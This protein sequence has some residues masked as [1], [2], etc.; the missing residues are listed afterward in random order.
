M[1][2]ASRKVWRGPL[3]PRRPPSSCVFAT[4]QRAE[5][6]TLGPAGARSRRPNEECDSTVVNGKLYLFGGNPVA[7]AGKQGA[8]P[9]TVFEYD[10]AA[11]RWTKKKNMPQPAHHNGVVGYNGKIYVFGGG[12]QRQPGGPTQFPIDNAWEYDPAA[13]TWK[14]LA[15]MPIRRLAAAAVES[16]GKIYVM[17]GVAAVSRSRKPVARRRGAASRARPQ[18]RVRP[19]DQHVADA[20]DDADAAQPHVR[21]AR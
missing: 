4:A 21:R 9:G 19:G 12:V 14:A 16:G 3:M 6:G 18:P 20:A 15:P 5:A 1:D 10:P 8:P 17:G 7:A 2:I 11:D 13:D